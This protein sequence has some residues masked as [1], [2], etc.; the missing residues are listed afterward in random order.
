[1]TSRT[2]SVA[3]QPDDGVARRT[4]QRTAMDD[5]VSDP[6]VFSTAMDRTANGVLA[7]LPTWWPV[8]CS[9]TTSWA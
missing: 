7:P 2:R 4:R 6:A 8:P 9:A 5:V 3:T 1:M